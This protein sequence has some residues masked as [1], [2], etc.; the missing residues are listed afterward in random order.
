MKELKIAVSMIVLLYK[1]NRYLKR[2]VEMYSENSRH[3]K[4]K[5]PHFILE[6]ILVNDYPDEK[7]SLTQTE[8]KL[9]NIF[10]VQNKENIGIHRS[11][12]E[13][14]QA[15]HGEFLFFLDQDDLISPYYVVE[16]YA[17]SSGC[18]AVICNM[19][20]GEGPYFQKKDVEALDLDCY[21]EGHN[22]ISSLGQV[23]LKKNAVPPEWIHY[24]LSGNGADD[25][26]LIFMML[27]KKQ[28][29]VEHRKALYYHV[30]TG[31]NFSSDF[32]AISFSV[33][34]VLKKLEKVG[35]LP[36]KA[37]DEAIKKRQDEMN[38]FLGSEEKYP[39]DIRQERRDN[40]K[41]INLYDRCLKNLESGYRFDSYIKT[42]RCNYIAMYGAGKMG[43]H[44]LYWMSHTDTKIEIVVDRMKKGFIDG[45]PIIGLD[46]A[47][48]KK[49]KFD[50]IVVTP[51]AGTE[52]IIAD[53]EEMF[54]CPIIPLE[55]VV[56]NMSCQLLESAH[57]VE[58][59]QYI[60]N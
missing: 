6:L 60:V 37:A 41:L 49:D 35:L 30:Y 34:E 55:A 23:F 4:E 28:H 54:S 18:D 2:I 50:L 46:E 48:R 1:G 10:V 44:F 39:C 11:K 5:Y 45:I 3:F 15:A 51:M 20:F 38:Q 47:Q 24:F 8:M 12:I 16:Q 7:I 9:L 32:M 52:K 19:D 26:Y 42:Y 40:I 59:A 53:L 58:T 36:Q 31:S 56:Y 25:Y 22:A 27:L 33:I 57:K 29:M 21:M 13:S 17:M 14:L 43:R